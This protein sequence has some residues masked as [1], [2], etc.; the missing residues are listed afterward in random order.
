MLRVLLTKMPIIALQSV[1]EYDFKVSEKWIWKISKTLYMKMETIAVEH[2]FNT[3]D[4]LGFY[5][6]WR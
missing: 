6:Q 5:C 2:D 4:Q 1:P 3:S